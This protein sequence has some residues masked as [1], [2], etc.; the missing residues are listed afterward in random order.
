MSLPRREVTLPEAE[1]EF[2]ISVPLF[3]D[4]KRPFEREMSVIIIID[5]FGD[6][7]IVTPRQHTGRRFL[8]CNFCS[9]Q[10]HPRPEMERDDLQVLT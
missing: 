5:K 6:G 8:L 7:S 2:E 3:H 9:C 1:K 10:H 4:I